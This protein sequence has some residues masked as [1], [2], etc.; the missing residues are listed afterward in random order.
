[1]VS[2]AQVVRAN[3]V[4]GFVN[5]KQLSQY[6]AV[7][8]DVKGL[9]RDYE[10][11]KSK[12]KTVGPDGKLLPYQL[13]DRL[14]GNFFAYDGTGRRVLEVNDGILGA[15]ASTVRSLEGL[16]GGTVVVQFVKPDRFWNIENV[17][18]DLLDKIVT[19]LEIREN[20]LQA[21]LDEAPPF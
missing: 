12:F 4:G 10:N 19:D 16:V 13:E 18:G 17:A 2:I 9:E 11:H 7:V 15:S 5:T 20:E 6:P 14:R 21:S 8:I 3:S 1:M